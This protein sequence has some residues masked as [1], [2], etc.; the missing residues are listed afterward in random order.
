M[1]C[2][3]T[4][5]KLASMGYKVKPVLKASKA[6][7]AILD[8]MELRAT[9]VILALK[10]SKVFKVFKVCKA[11][12]DLKELRATKVIPECKVKLDTGS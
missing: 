3:V 10:V 5:V 2:R 8:L 9:K 6:C 1:E 12:P 4:K 7:R 11:I